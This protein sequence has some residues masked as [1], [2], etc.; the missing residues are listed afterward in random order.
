M[1]WTSHRPWTV[2]RELG[3]VVPMPTEPAEV[4]TYKS[5]VLTAKSPVVERA[6]FRFDPAAGVMVK[7]PDDVVIDG[8][9]M[10]G[11]ITDVP[12]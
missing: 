6:T 5:S 2:R 12:K 7:A 3:V 4:S 1:P 9:V 10:R 8:V 11:L